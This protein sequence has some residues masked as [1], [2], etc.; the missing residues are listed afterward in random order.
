M[1]VTARM[2]IQNDELSDV[3]VSDNA[4]AVMVSLTLI[5]STSSRDV[6]LVTLG[7]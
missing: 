5:F 1:R 6:L 3:Q 2:D 4:L 7:D